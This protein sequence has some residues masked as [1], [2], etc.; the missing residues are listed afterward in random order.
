MLQIKELQASRS[1]VATFTFL[2][3]LLRLTNNVQK[4]SDDHR[5]RVLD[6]REPPFPGV[7][8]RVI[9][10]CGRK[11]SMTAMSLERYG[12]HILPVYEDPVVAYVE[13]AEEKDWIRQTP[14]YVWHG[15]RCVYCS[16]SPP[17]SL[18][19]P[20]RLARRALWHL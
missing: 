1:I 2:S 5:R 20:P 14:D 7:K 6:G 10:L 13:E 16:V 4:S 9:R 15:A 17:V 11:S 18:F 19:V 3:Q 12:H 8:E